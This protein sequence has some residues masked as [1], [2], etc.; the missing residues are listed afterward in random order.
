MNTQNSETTLTQ[1]SKD[2]STGKYII[3]YII[4]RVEHYTF[5]KISAVSETHLGNND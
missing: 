5:M 4:H 2:P 1:K 3:Y